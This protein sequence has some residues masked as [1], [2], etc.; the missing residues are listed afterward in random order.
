MCAATNN[1][2]YRFFTVR[3]GNVTNSKELIY[4]E[5]VKNVHGTVPEFYL[6]S[7]SLGKHISHNNGHAG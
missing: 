3:K 7:A 4:I 5:V 1:C 6:I 2:Q